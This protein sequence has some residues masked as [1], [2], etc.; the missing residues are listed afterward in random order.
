MSATPVSL[1]ERLRLAPDDASW[2]RLVD[3]YTPLIRGWLRRCG[4][5][6]S[7]ADDL[8]QEAL[9]VLVRE[10]PQ[11]RREPRTGA[12]RRWLRLIAV[13][14]LRAFWR[15]RRR[16]PDSLGDALAQLEDPDS[17][18]SRLWERQHDQH[19]ARRLLELIRPDFEPATWEAFR[20]VTL[21]G[22]P[23]AAVA[24]QLGLSPNAVRIAKSR[25]LSRFRRE[26]EGLLD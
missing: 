6:E 5:Q 11:F 13:N 26:A 19:V 22:R 10:L 8:T 7:D 1:L 14:R 12:F 9:G 17:G 24:E 20:L 25:V 4:L 21:E 18:L 3:L 23:T 2:Q 16:G 15:E